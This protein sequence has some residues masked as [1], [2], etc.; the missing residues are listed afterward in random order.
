M[1]TEAEPL[2]SNKIYNSEDT[3]EAINSLITDDNPKTSGEDTG[4]SFNVVPTPTE[5]QIT[6]KRTGC[7][8]YLGVFYAL[9][10]VNCSALSSTLL[11]K[12]SHIN[13][14]TVNLYA[15][16]TAFI[17]QVALML[18]RHYMQKEPWMLN[19]LPLGQ[20]KMTIF[21]LWV[22]LCLIHII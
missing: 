17:M 16:L 12:L 13:P 2:A 19:I 8:R 18:Y 20:H 4:L 15:F 21:L 9:L 5:S 3:G 11:K 6:N 14:I 7:R 1:E 22:C 10:A